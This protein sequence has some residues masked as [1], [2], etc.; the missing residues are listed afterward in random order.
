MCKETP[1][2]GQHMLEFM[3]RFRINHA[4]KG[5]HYFIYFGDEKKAN[6]FIIKLN[7]ENYCTGRKVNYHSQADT[8]GYFHNIE[9]IV[10]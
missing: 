7:R 5:K 6:K 3:L 4:K 8:V 2:G 1:K 9:V 10:F